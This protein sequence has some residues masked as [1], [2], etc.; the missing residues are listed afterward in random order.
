MIKSPNDM[1]LNSYTFSH[2]KTYTIKSIGINNSKSHFTA[3]TGA[4]VGGD[5]DL[6]DWEIVL[7]F[8]GIFLFILI[9][10]LIILIII[11]SKK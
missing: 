4:S 10:I 9:I 2:M 11:R 1:E 7:I 6:K 3:G 8:F 5:G